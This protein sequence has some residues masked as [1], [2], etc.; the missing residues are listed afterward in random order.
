MKL[1]FCLYVHILSKSTV[2]MVFS[3]FLLCIYKYTHVLLCVCRCRTYIPS[4]LKTT[5]IF[6]QGTFLKKNWNYQGLPSMLNTVNTF[7]RLSTVVHYPQCKCNMITFF[8][9][10]G[11]LVCLKFFT[12][13]TKRFNVYLSTY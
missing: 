12:I 9:K 8:P 13:M 7:N 2:D 3:T 6:L 1:S 5:C 10:V 4:A 11:Y